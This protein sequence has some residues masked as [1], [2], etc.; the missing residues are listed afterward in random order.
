MKSLIKYFL[1]IPARMSNR[2]LFMRK[3]VRYKTFPKI[4]GK[5]KI[6]KNGLIFLGRKV[7]INSG[8][9]YNPIGGDTRTVF[10]VA[11]GA[12]LTIGDYSGLSNSTIVCREEVTIGS[13]VN[14]GGGCKIYDTDFHALDPQQR[15]NKKTDIGKN[16]PVRIDDHA[17]IGAHSIIL[18]GVHI[19]KN[20][21]IGAGS[22]VSKSVPDNQIWAGNPAKYIKDVV[23][24]NE[25]E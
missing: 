15:M 10:S 20:A 9:A 13:Y 1:T 4:N 3:N 2:F 24:Q 17:F 25:T 11:K 16:R 22:V 8:P 21:I 23:L 5:I 7:K 19:G 14:V 12:K 6:F 18:K